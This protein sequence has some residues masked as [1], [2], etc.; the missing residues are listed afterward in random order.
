LQTAIQAAHA[1]D[2]FT[3]AR[4]ISVANRLVVLP[5][6]PGIVVIEQAGADS[7][8]TQLRLVA[9]AARQV[10]A[11]VSGAL[12][13]F[14]GPQATTPQLNIAMG[15][16]EPH[17]A[18]LTAVPNTLAQARDQL[19]AAIQAADSGAAF[20]GALVGTLDDRLVVLPGTDRTEAVFSAAPGD[21]TTISDLALETDRPAIAAS[22]GGQAP[23]PPAALERATIWGATYVKE[24]TLA[25][26]VIFTGV[27][28]VEHRQAGCARF[29]YVSPASHTPQRYRCQPD[30]EITAE[31]AAAEQEAKQN[32]TV[33]T[34]AQAAA[35]AARVRAWLRPAFTASRYGRAAYGQLS[36]A[37]PTQITTGADD[38]AEMGV[39]NSLQGAV[40]EANLR[41][42][43][44]EHLRFG[45]EA[46]IFYVT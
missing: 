41:T 17:T 36:A 37:C 27:V 38:G 11:L 19:Q 18:T 29:S 42:A 45:L 32:N 39:F 28:L 3:G 25:S 23:G 14:T 13:G 31:I 30:L 40:R 35:I 43:L 22:E 21:A 15:G 46:G 33:L 6:T 10:F 24:L 16:E 2:A 20:T 4:V 26:E 9:G 8:A 12:T 44:D 5:G 34:P 7:T 1:S